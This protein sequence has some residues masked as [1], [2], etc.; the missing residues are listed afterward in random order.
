M[1]TDLQGRLRNI[2]LDRSKGLHPVF[3]AVVN[4]FDAIEESGRQGGNITV[5]ILREPMPLLSEGKLDGDLQGER[6]IVGF[7]ITDNGVGFTEPN[8]DAFC[9]SDSTI[10]LNRGGK[11]I[12][13]FLWLKAFEKARVASVF[14]SKG[15][16]HERT[17]LFS[18]K[19]DG[20]RDHECKQLEGDREYETTV[21]LEGFRTRYQEQCTRVCET[22]AVRLIEHCLI[23]FLSEHCP[24]V[25]IKDGDGCICLNSLFGRTVKETSTEKSL[26]IGGR[27]VAI[28]NLKLHESS[29]NKHKIVYCANR[30]EVMTETLEKYIPDLGRKLVDGEENA[31]IYLA[32][33]TS[34]YLD[35][36]VNA[37]RTDF[38]FAEEDTLLDEAIPLEELRAGILEIARE[39]LGSEL[40]AVRDEKIRSY[41]EYIEQEA[42]QYRILA[43]HYPESIGDLPPGLAPQKLDVELYKARAEVTAQ[44]REKGQKLIDM[45]VSRIEDEEE[46]RKEYRKYLEEENE[47]GKATLAEYIVHRRIILRL[48][49]NSLKKGGDKGEYRLEEEVHR[50]V[51]PLR[52]TSNDIEL[53]EQNLWI[54]DEGLSYH[55]YLASD[56]EFGQIDKVGEFEGR[57]RADIMV[58]NT[59]L[60]LVD[61]DEVPYP[62]VSIIE[63]K[64]PGREGYGEDE[65]PI[66]QIYGYVKK[67]K[68][69]RA[70]DA[71]GRL[72]GVSAATTFFGFLL[73]DIT[74]K[75]QNLAELHNLTRTPVSGHS[76]PAT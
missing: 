38:S 46:Y 7:S 74:E 49:E 62:S 51:Y 57:E 15:K 63:F 64:R 73:C 75:I 54:L 31:Y 9:T 48:L 17:F 68:N 36:R 37:A 18:P 3:E 6:P 10:K 76:K 60:A 45:D 26:E 35:E 39:Y 55:R 1:K 52:T 67:I 41:T 22:I 4:S 56:K 21:V 50:I 47:V 71:D 20:I 34:D 2:R 42:P 69:G 72:I 13:R 59:P 44:V 40:D 25:T 8:Y 65:D 61:Q 19:D 14:K 23:Y 66:S 70:K 27:S 58:F 5:D 28:T 30:R 32:Y 11:G 16:W 53:E 33:I 43:H 29:T 24:T 12:G